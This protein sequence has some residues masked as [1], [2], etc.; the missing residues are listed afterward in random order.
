MDDNAFTRAGDKGAPG[1][2]LAFAGACGAL[3]TF[4]IYRRKDAAAAPAPARA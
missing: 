3:A 4:L 1:Y 2:W